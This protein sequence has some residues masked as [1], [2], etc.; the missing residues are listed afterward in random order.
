MREAKSVVT[1]LKDILPKEQF[2][3]KIQAICNG[4][5]IASERLSPLKK[6]VT[7]YLYGGDRTRKM[8]LWKKQKEGKK[9]LKGKGKV[10][11]STETF[12]KLLRK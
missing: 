3:V 7:G 5:I 6:D 12:L 4:R 10:H 2:E 9:K 1:A 11:I 8:K